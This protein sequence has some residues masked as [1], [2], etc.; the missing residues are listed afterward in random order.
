VIGFA[1]A[2]NSAANWPA[3]GEITVADYRGTT[4][5]KIAQCL[6]GGPILAESTTNTRSFVL[7]GYWKSTAAITRLDLTLASGNYVAGSKFSLYGI[8]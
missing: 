5:N 8:L 7:T 6:Q 3:I 4:F 1:T 2:A